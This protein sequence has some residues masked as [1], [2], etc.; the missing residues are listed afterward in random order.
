MLQNKNACFRFATNKL[1]IKMKYIVS[2][3][4]KVKKFYKFFFCNCNSLHSIYI[5]FTFV[6]VDLVNKFRFVNIVYMFNFKN[7]SMNDI[8]FSE[9]YYVVIIVPYCLLFI[10]NRLA[11]GT[12]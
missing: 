2:V 12:F 6:F 3:E 7:A 9:F 11:I 10:M 4:E 8:V 5:Y 1:R